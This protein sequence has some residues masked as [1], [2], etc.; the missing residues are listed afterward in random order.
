MLRSRSIV[1]TPYRKFSLTNLRNVCIF[2]TQGSSQRDA[3]LIRV[4]CHH[5][6]A[7][8]C[9]VM[10]SLFFIKPV[11]TFHLPQRPPARLLPQAV[12][13]AGHEG[14]G[15]TGKP[16]ERVA[17]NFDSCCRNCCGTPPAVLCAVSTEL[18]EVFVSFVAYFF[19]SWPSAAWCWKPGNP[20]CGCMT[21]IRGPSPAPS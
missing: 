3:S 2:T 4:H 20:N 8:S 18:D 12:G 5:P 13:R 11:K 19:S 15:K 6:F 17:F 9:V 1:A 14:F 21:C 16:E 10:H 7:R